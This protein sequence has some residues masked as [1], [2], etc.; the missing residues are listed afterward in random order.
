MLMIKINTMRKQIILLSI[1]FSC[2][3]LCKDLVAQTKKIIVSGTV[4]DAGTND[5]MVG[6]SV[7]SGK[8]L[9]V[10]TQTDSKGHYSVSVDDGATLV[11]TYVSYSQKTIKLNAGQ[12]S[13]NVSLKEDNKTM[14][15]VVIR[16][17]QKRTREQTTGSSFIVSG[18]EVQ[19]VPVS[20]VEQ[21]LQGKVAGLNIQLNTGAPGLRGTVNIRGLS[22]ISTTGAG[23]ETFLQPTSPLYVIDGVP[24]DA[25]KASEF[26]FQQQGPGVS[27]ISL[28]PQED[29]ASIEVLKDATAT[30]LYGSRGAYGV[31]LIQTVRGNS[32]IPRIR[33]TGNFYMN[34]IP[35]LRSILGGSNE[36]DLK[37]YQINTYG[38]FDDRY[39]ISNT[40]FLTDSLNPFYNNST[41]WQGVFYQ[42]TYNQTHN[43]QLDGGDTKFSYKTNLSYY[44]DKGIIKNTG[45]DRY[46]LNMN[47]DYKPTSRISFFGSI[48]GNVGK[49]KKANGV[50]LLQT[51]VA[52]D[53]QKSSLLPGPSYFQATSS[54]LSALQTNT[55]AGPKN[56]NT[57]IEGRYELIPGLNITSAASYDYN[58]DTEDTFTPAA[59]NNQFAKIFSLYGYTS[60][61]YNR[62]NA[63][64]TRSFNEKH[65]LF[66]NLF[67]EMYV[68]K[69]Q[70]S[71]TRLERSPNDQ[72]QGPLGYDGYYSRGGG[73]LTTFYDQNQI[74][75]AAAFT[76]D[77]EKKYILDLTYRIDGTS[78]N[79]NKD[80][81]SK[82]PSIG[83]KWNFN[84]ENWLKDLKWLSYGDIR[85]TAGKNI[86]P[87]GTL[88]DI[89]GKYTPKGFYNNNPRVGID[90]E[91]VP[92]PLLRPKNVTQFNLGFDLGLFNGKLDVIFDTYYK[93]V[94]NELF[95]SFL[96]NTLAFQ[97]YTSN[98]AALANY[99]YE[100]SFSSRPLSKDSKFNWTVSVNGAW[101]NDVLTKLPEE[102]NGQFI[103]FDIY[104]PYEQHLA[105]RVG[106]NSLANYLY[107]NQGVYDSTNDVPIDPITGARYRNGNSTNFLNSFQGGDARF[108]D[109]NGDYI[110][111][112]RD[113]QVVG[114]T[115]PVLTGGLSN[116][117]SYTMPSGSSLSLNIYATYTAKR[118][119]LNNALADRLRLLDN[120][121]GTKDGVLGGNPLA[122]VPVNDLNMWT[123]PGSTNAKFANAYDYAHNAYVN[124]YRYAQTLWMETGSYFKINQI[125]LSYSF[126]KKMARRIGLNNIRTFLSA[127]NI[128]TFSPYSG[129]NPEGVTAIG[130]DGS[131]GYPVPRVYNLGFNVEF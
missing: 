61:L 101:N 130:R 68:K 28:I 35:K 94:D 72:F 82:N 31:I 42:N 80:P 125:T 78:N 18:K 84:K 46:S 36:R 16:G 15:E 32:E 39:K 8:P 10:L 65:N 4:K 49:I 85:V 126:A 66:I 118:S 113:L 5:T 75:F 99:G 12:T 115:Q 112:S 86:F 116:T 27:P 33:Y 92:N 107:V 37:L 56:L 53:G 41:D 97:K 122:V 96:S 6:V 91:F 21:L 89:Y 54:V 124:N 87:V 104:T 105:K 40:P 55:D 20:N 63:S 50:G 52:A 119:I 98:D 44:S 60:Q 9:K 45:F 71:I 22:T 127:S 62:N 76:Y 13:L 25:D 95:T 106:R 131:G 102:Y 117:L 69:G 121:F 14:E 81:Y 59:A 48:R 2:I 114:N 129:P 73:I 17:Y 23:N 67:S 3:F 51:G 26:G 29:I 120:P 1:F 11:F 90:Y 43:V 74:S 19:D 100:L 109:A 77:F 24:M 108:L 111:D 38:R 34:A 7:A 58:V 123:G 64:Y 47:M 110:L 103:E 88:V 128:I 57:Y 93:K 79:G 30:A 70:S 83:L